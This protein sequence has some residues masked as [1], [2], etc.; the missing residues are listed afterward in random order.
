M[1]IPQCIRRTI[2]LGRVCWVT[3]K[4]MQI[5]ACMTSS[6]LRTPCRVCRWWY[7]LWHGL[8][9]TTTR[10]WPRLQRLFGTPGARHG[11]RL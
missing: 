1:H 4:W 6:V 7:C 11:H 2:S 3:I 8:Q 5:A 10:I 9:R